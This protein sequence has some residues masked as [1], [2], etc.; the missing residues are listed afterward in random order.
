MVGE[1]GVRPVLQGSELRAIS[2][3]AGK[4]VDVLLVRRATIPVDGTRGLIMLP[5]PLHWAMFLL[6]LIRCWDDA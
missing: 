4:A 1:R 2:K 5:A 3:G 6:E